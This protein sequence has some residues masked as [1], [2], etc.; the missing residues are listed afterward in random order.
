MQALR[1]TS[2]LGKEAGKHVS[3]YALQTYLQAS[4]EDH[5]VR[6]SIDI[7]QKRLLDP[8]IIQCENAHI[9]LLSSSHASLQLDHTSKRS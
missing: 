7:A 6:V 2:D 8:G 9:I 5:Q 3:K 4:V 1:A